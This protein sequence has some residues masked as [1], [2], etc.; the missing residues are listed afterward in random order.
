MKVAY[1][2]FDVFYDALLAL[3]QFK[4]EIMEIFTC[5]VDNEFEF[6]SQVIAFAEKL[7]IPYQIS[8]ITLDDIN[9]LQKSG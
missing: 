2:G 8:P 9:R 4:C 6:N 5:E 7:K 1:I 3:H